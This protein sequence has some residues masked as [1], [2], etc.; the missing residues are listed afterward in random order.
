MY[1]FRLEALT[2]FKGNFSLYTCLDVLQPSVF[3]RIWKSSLLRVIRCTE[4]AVEMLFL[5]HLVR[6]IKVLL[7]FAPKVRTICAIRTV[8]IGSVLSN[9]AIIHGSTR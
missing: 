4:G 6:K 9:D 7:K 5:R 2:L 1:F 3:L 8:H